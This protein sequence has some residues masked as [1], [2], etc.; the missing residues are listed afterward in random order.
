MEE[1]IGT[2]VLAVTM[3]DMLKKESDGISSVFDQMTGLQ[4]FQKT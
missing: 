1:L 3:I 4:L 2:N